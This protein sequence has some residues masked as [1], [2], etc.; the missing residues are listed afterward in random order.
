MCGTPGEFSRLSYAYSNADRSALAGG[1][2]HADLEGHEVDLRVRAGDDWT[3]GFSHRYDIL[4]VEPLSLQTNGHLHTVSFPI[5]RQFRSGG[6]SF[7]V[8]V[9]PAVS[10]SSNVV[11]DPGEYTS[12]VLQLLGAF[13]WD[14][15]VSTNATLRFGICGDH[16]FGGYE[17][18]P[19]VSLDWQPNTEWRI[20]LGF[21]TTRLTFDAVPKLRLGLR[22]APD[23]NEWHVR[24]RAMNR[25]SHLT[26]DAWLAEG[27][28][29]FKA[30]E[31]LSLAL[32]V[33]RR[34]DNRYDV[35][36]ADDS[37]V[38]LDADATTRYG[39]AVEWRF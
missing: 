20:E 33:G 25:Q 13:V 15:Q 32:A 9:A 10:A 14:R 27:T 2:G 37:R 1:L 16:R 4:D 36:L 3:F 24:N 5:H 35:T 34:F 17:V 31:R 8:S 30:H 12:D 22:I 18:Y 7:R 6:Q 21:P 28:V 39:A 11:K 23:G 29:W 19:T 26:N 38:N